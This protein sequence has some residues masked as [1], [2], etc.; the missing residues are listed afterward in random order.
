MFSAVKNVSIFG[1]PE[2]AIAFTAENMRS[3]VCA[4]KNTNSQPLIANGQKPETWT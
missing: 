4:E 2:C 1:M 3:G